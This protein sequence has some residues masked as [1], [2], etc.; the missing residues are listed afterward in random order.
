MSK[1]WSVLFLTLITMTL[2]DLILALNGRPL[3]E[4]VI[5]NSAQ[6]GASVT[7]LVVQGVLDLMKLLGY[8]LEEDK[9]DGKST[10]SSGQE[11]H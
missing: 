8:T 10:D 1:K 11:K 2:T 5:T 6:G 7:Y 9:A 3:M 4:F